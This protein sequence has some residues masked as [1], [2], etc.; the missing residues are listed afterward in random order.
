M[1]AWVSRIKPSPNSK[2]LSRSAQINWFIS[3]ESQ[4]GRPFIQTRALPTCCGALGLRS[5]AAGHS[6][7]HSRCG[8]LRPPILLEAKRVKS[9]DERGQVSAKSGLSKTDAHCHTHLPV[10]V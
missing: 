3:T 9:W 5:E 2:R 6:K 8:K 1:L 7:T 4:P 10:L